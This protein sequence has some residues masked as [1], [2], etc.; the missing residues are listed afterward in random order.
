MFA[1]N[2]AKSTAAREHHQG[3]LR[4]RVSRVVLKVKNHTQ[5][6]RVEHLG[7]VAPFAS[8]ASWDQAVTFHGRFNR[9]MNAFENRVNQ[10]PGACLLTFYPTDCTGSNVAIHAFDS[11]MGRVLMGGE[12]GF[13]NVAALPAE[14]R[15]FH[16]LHS[17]VCALCS[18]DD[19]CGGGYREENGQ[20]PNVGSTVAGS[21]TIV[22]SA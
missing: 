7:P 3:G 2:A 15:R 18:D 17:A 16:V 8:F 19:V 13:H 6:Y 22:L 9:V 4:L 21:K 14:L 20:F 5:L 10:L 1:V 11:R 12:F